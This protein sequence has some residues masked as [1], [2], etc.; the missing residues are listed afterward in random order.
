MNEMM[1]QMLAQKAGLSPEQ[2]ATFT[3]SSAEGTPDGRMAALM[4]MMAE[5]SQTQ[6]TAADDHQLI[7]EELERRR[8]QVHMLTA[9]L[10]AAMSAVAYVGEAIGACTQC[11]GTDQNCA[12]CA[13]QGK[14]GAYEPDE[15]ALR[16]LVEAPLARLGLQLV[17]VDEA[18]TSPQ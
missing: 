1:M 16:S 15:P 12:I 10:K 9:R 14:P 4:Q 5:R 2:V 3:S 8:R 13:G 18:P 6:E 7:A 11:W 17:S